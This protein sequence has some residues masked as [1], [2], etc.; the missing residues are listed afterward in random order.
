MI[1]PHNT[2]TQEDNDKKVLD[3][4]AF[5][6][7][8]IGLILIFVGAGL[9]RPALMNLSVE[10]FYTGNKSRFLAWQDVSG[11]VAGL[12]VTIIAP[13]LRNEKMHVQEQLMHVNTIIFS[14]VIITAIFCHG[15]GSYAFYRASE[16]KKQDSKDYKNSIRSLKSVLMKQSQEVS[17]PSLL[18]FFLPLIII[19]SL[20]EQS[21]TYFVLQSLKS[22]RH[23][24]SYKIQPV[25]VM[26]LHPLFLII[27]LLFNKL[28]FYRILEK[29]SY[30]NPLKKVT[31]G[32][33][34]AIGAYISAF[35]VEYQLNTSGPIMPRNEEA[36]FRMFNA[37]KCDYVIETFIRNRQYFH[38]KHMEMYHDVRTILEKES[39]IV[40]YSIK[41]DEQ[42]WEGDPDMCPSLSG[43]LQL[44]KGKEMGYLIE[45]VNQSKI[46]LLCY[47][48]D[49]SRS[50]DMRAKVR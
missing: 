33:I 2:S 4:F 18:L 16:G 36:H 35:Y 15:I 28:I 46:E 30:S 47:V 24:F 41:L 17:N 6:S 10:H 49:S 7:H 48:G 44:R 23:I 43:N 37:M 50:K 9:A 13:F 8:L 1:Y 29:T 26:A 39:E 38:L 32:C 12:V 3:E 11:V 42:G 19:W 20:L 21:F 34:F 22:D 27:F 5:M 31:I 14:V 40:W 25:H 45:Y